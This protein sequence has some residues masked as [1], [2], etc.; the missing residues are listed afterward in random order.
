MTEK[1]EKLRAGV[2]WK[3]TPDRYGVVSRLLHWGMAYLLLWQLI[4]ALAWR[5]F[6]PSAT[7]ETIARFG[8]DHGTVGLLTLALIVI[9]SVWGWA[10]RRN[11]PPS[12]AGRMGMV[13][14][15]AHLTLYALMFIIPAIAL[16]RVYGSGEGWSPW[17]LP[18]IPETGR[19]V[20]WMVAPANALHGLFAW[21]LGGLIAVHIL[22]ALYHRV[23]LRDG[24][25]SRMAGLKKPQK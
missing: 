12:T 16:L 15:S 6:Y 10:N 25:F 19:K 23:I 1:N 20:A 21:L 2:T 11:R 24:I 14:R 9:R 3:D 18:F 5:L 4:M 22:A 17:D 7:V 8:P 13:A